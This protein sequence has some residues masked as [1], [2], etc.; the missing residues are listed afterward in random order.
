[1]NIR[2]TFDYN[3]NSK[4]ILRNMY[5]LVLVH[6]YLLLRRRIKVHQVLLEQYECNLLLIS[7]GLR[8]G[9]KKLRHR[10]SPVPWCAPWV[11]CPD[12]FSC[13]RGDVPW[14]A[15]RGRLPPSTTWAPLFWGGSGHG[16]DARCPRTRLA[17]LWLRRGPTTDQRVPTRGPAPEGQARRPRGTSCRAGR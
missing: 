5:V 11:Y 13:R 17:G 9:R 3:F 2:S 6:Q 14:G 10:L 4:H 7:N 1:M 8:A 16:W 12:R 15:S